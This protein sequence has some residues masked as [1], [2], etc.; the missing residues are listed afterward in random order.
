MTHQ[1]IY[2]SSR[3]LIRFCLSPCR[4]KQ[5]CLPNLYN[6]LITFDTLIRALVHLHIHAIIGALK[7]ASHI[8]MGGNEISMTQCH[9]YVTGWDFHTQPCGKTIKTSSEQQFYRG[10]TLLM[11]AV[12]GE[13]PDGGVVTVRL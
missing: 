8:R 7:F 4:F 2:E 9:S 12:N 6:P 13:W 11:K 10:K 1:H 3:H 5:F